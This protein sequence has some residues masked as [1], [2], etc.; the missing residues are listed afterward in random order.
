[1][2]HLRLRT[3]SF[4]VLITVAVLLSAGGGRGVAAASVQ[5]SNLSWQNCTPAGYQCATLDVPLDY[6]DASKGTIRLALTRLPATSPS[7]RIGSLLANPGGPGAS[8][9]DFLHN[10]APG[11]AP[12][13][14][15]HFDL[16]AFDPRGVGQSSPIVCH[17]TIQA[18][19]AVNPSPS[20][21]AGWAAADAAAKTF[22]DGCAA[23]YGNILPYLGTKNVAR[24]MESV[25]VALGD[26]KLTYLGYSYG[27]AIGAVYAD[28]YP[29]HV[30]AMVLDGAVDLAQT[31]E[32]IN[33]TQMIGFERAFNAYIANC[34]ATR[35][36]GSL[37]PQTTIEGLIAQVTKQPLPAPQ[38]DRPAGPGEVLTGII[39]C[40]YSQ[41]EWSQLTLA[42]R[43]AMQGDGSGFVELTDAYLERNPDGSYP[44]LLEANAAVNYVDESCPKD[45]SVYPA[46]GERFAKVAP[47][48][49]ESAATSG[50]MC[51]YWPVTPDPPAVPKAH[52]APA[53]VVIA[54]TNDPATPYEWGLAMSKQLESGRLIIHRGQGH[55]VYA[56]GDA[57][58]DNAVNAY[59][60]NLTVPPVG[61]TCGNGPPPP[62]AGSTGAAT[63]GATSSA[64][65]SPSPSVTATVV[66]SATAPLPPSTGSASGARSSGATNVAIIA[67]GFVV[68]A[69]LVAGTVVFLQRRQ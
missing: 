50:V 56:S 60:I 24:D 40:M 18:L 49:G 6:A 43:L 67:G 69:L 28:M 17:S 25:R 8:A 45:P 32:Q 31:F 62:E 10:W 39:F 34:R 55:T 2:K 14:R 68:L 64:V 5:A 52:G 29:T 59:L 57:C 35:C 58:V 53:I 36:M 9:I 41:Q 11:L 4:F 12:E 51:A 44:N 3:A 13:I 23:K 42:T 15:S 19:V 54:T 38:A 21:A 7:Q 33:Q 65:A 20:T 16:V 61:L 27:T 1:M 22:A 37:D 66:P 26:P 47:H 46:M 48:F 30:R 63:P